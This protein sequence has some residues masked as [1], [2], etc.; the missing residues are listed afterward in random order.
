M[1]QDWQRLRERVF[2]KRVKKREEQRKNCNWIYCACAIN[3][4]LMETEHHFLR[5]PVDIPHLPCIK[6]MSLFTL[7]LIIDAQQINR[8][9]L[10]LLCVA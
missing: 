6:S 7:M 8:F 9:K 1:Y 4:C 10:Y 2:R 5:T 3:Y